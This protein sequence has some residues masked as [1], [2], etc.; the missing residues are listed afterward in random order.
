MSWF[1]FYDFNVAICPRVFL[2]SVPKLITLWMQYINKQNV[3]IYI[4]TQMDHSLLFVLLFHL[5]NPSVHR[6]TVPRFRYLSH[7]A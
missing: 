1:R 2:Q 3:K 4:S 7:F 5:C 6:P